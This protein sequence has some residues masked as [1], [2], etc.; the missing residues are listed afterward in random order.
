MDDPSDVDSCLCHVAVLSSLATHRYLSVANTHSWAFQTEQVKMSVVSRTPK[1]QPT[2]HLQ[3]SQASDRLFI[4]HTILLHPRRGR[5]DASTLYRYSHCTTDRR[6]F[7]I[8]DLGKFV[9]RSSCQARQ[10]RDESIR[11][12]HLDAGEPHIGPAGR[13]AGASRRRALPDPRA[14]LGG[15]REDGGDGRR[16]ALRPR[17]R[18][19]DHPSRQG[20]ARQATGRPGGVV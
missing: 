2:T 4:S 1:K 11:E 16:C 9:T 5:K 19:R 3:R 12:A 7:A 10:I 14:G 6:G 8:P 15:G 20:M 17:P 13:G 18:A